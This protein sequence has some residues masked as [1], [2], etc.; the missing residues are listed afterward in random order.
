MINAHDGALS[1]AGIGATT[2]DLGIFKK[3]LPTHVSV[4]D[5]YQEWV[6][7]SQRLMAGHLSDLIAQPVFVANFE[8]NQGTGLSG[9]LGRKR[10]RWSR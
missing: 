6:A 10:F 7:Q 4:K 1:G 3:Y 8:K 2:F 5:Q 9:M